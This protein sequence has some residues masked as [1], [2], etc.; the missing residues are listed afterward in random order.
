MARAA[1]RFLDDL[2]VELPDHA[3]LLAAVRDICR[4]DPRR[5]AELRD[6]PLAVATADDVR[7]W[8]VGG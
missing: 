3:T 7:E 5:M 6:V 1:D 8:E 2:A 4:S